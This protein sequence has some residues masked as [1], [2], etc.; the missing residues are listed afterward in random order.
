MNVGGKIAIV[1][2]A[3]SGIGRS[4]ALELAKQGATV[5]VCARR[6]EKLEQALAEIKPHGPD[7]SYRVCDCTRDEQVKET[8]R[9]VH[10]KHGRIDIMLNVAGIF[11]PKFVVDATWE[12]YYRDMD[13][14]FLGAVR[15][16]HEVLPIMLDQKRGVILNTSSIN[17][18][19]RPPGISA[20]SATKAAVYAYSDTLYK[21]VSWKGI[22]VGVIQPVLVETEMTEATGTEKTMDEMIK[23]I[24]EGSLGHYHEMLSSL[25]IQDPGE[26]AREIIKRGIEKEY[27]E[28]YTGK[29]QIW[30]AMGLTMK[31]LPGL[32]RGMFS[33]LMAQMEHLASVLEENPAAAEALS[34]RS[35][36]ASPGMQSLIDSWGPFGS[37][38]RNLFVA[39]DEGVNR[40]IYRSGKTVQRLQSLR[41][42]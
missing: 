15:F 31:A 13:V 37:A 24:A 22:H 9:W 5:T 8:V 10:E 6:E 34:R 11:D 26:S 39:L 33:L 41:R 17:E 25:K 20:Y 23:E 18:Q 1:N 21:E 36:G 4:L 2:G 29:P 32:S 19:M 30:T 7:S 40:T 3:S 27:F 28:V 38:V 14:C 42:G 35:P 12:D 16:N